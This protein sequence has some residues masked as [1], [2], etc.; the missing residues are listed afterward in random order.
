MPSEPPNPHPQGAPPPPES[1][2]PT[3]PEELLSGFS[4]LDRLSAGI[5][6]EFVSTVGPTPA[7]V[8]GGGS[9]AEWITEPPTASLD[10]TASMSPDSSPT[11]GI[12]FTAETPTMALPEAT[13]PPSPETTTPSERTT[14]GP[15]ARY[16]P[17]IPLGRGGMGEV[18][19][20]FDRQLGREIAIKRIRPELR[21]HPA[22]R[23]RFRREARVLARL[24]HPGV[25]PLHEVGE[26]QDGPWFSM[27]VVG[28]QGLDERVNAAAAN[29]V[30]HRADL[31]DIFLRVC[32][33]IAFAHAAGI[34][35][36]D[37]KPENIRIGDF[38][39]VQLLDWGLAAATESDGGVP[40][41][42][43]KP[44]QTRQG[45]L[46]GTPGW[47]A[48]EQAHGL[49][50]GAPADIWALGGLLRYCLTARTPNEPLP[51]THRIPRAL[52]AILSHAM[53]PTPADRYP[54]ALAL[55]ADLRAFLR[56]EPI[57][58]A[59]FTPIEHL[60]RILT[61]HRV[62][63]SVTTLLL[64]AT[65]AL[66]FG[67][68]QYRQA[69]IETS[70]RTQAAELARSRAH[71]AAIAAARQAWS[72]RD[73]TTAALFAT[74]ALQHE[75]T[76][77][78]AWGLVLAAFDRGIPRLLA[79]HPDPDPHGLWVRLALPRGSFILLPTNPASPL[80]CAILHSDGRLLPIPR[81]FRGLP[82][83]QEELTVASFDPTRGTVWLIT[84]DL[85]LHALDPVT[86][87]ILSTT[88]LP[89]RDALTT[90]GARPFVRGLLTLPD[91]TLALTLQ[92]IGHNLAPSFPIPPGA[93]LY[94][95]D[96][97]RAAVL[98][99]T[100]ELPH[101]PGAVFAHLPMGIVLGTHQGGLRIFDPETLTPRPPINLDGLDPAAV[102][103][104]G[105]GFAFASLVHS[106]PIRIGIGTPH[107]ISTFPVD[108]TPRMLT[109]VSRTSPP[110]PN[111][112][113]EPKP[114]LFI[115]EGLGPLWWDTATAS[116]RLRLP[117]LGTP[118]SVNLPSP[119]GNAL[120][121]TGGRQVRL[122]Q[123]PSP[124]GPQ[125]SRHTTALAAL[126]AGMG[127]GYVACDPR[128]RPTFLQ[129]PLWEPRRG[130]VLHGDHA[131][132]IE[133]LPD[134]ISFSLSSSHVLFRP[135][136]GGAPPTWERRG[137]YAEHGI[138]NMLVPG[139][140]GQAI[141]VDGRLDTFLLDG[142]PFATTPGGG[143]GDKLRALARVDYGT[144]H[145]LVGSHQGR[146]LSVWTLGPDGFPAG[147][148]TVRTLPKSVRPEI[149][150]LIDRMGT[151]RT[152][153]L[154]AAERFGPVHL[155]HLPSGET[156]EFEDTIDWDL[157]THFFGT[158][159]QY[160]A[161][162]GFDSELRIWDVHHARLLA[163]LPRWGGE[164]QDIVDG[165]P[166]E[167]LVLELGEPQVHGIA[168]G[169]LDLPPAELK[170]LLEA[171]TGFGVREGELILLP[172]QHPLPAPWADPGQLLREPH[173]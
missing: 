100:P 69:Q 60:E 51:G 115:Q 48:P 155:L 14:W 47:W 79:Q 39:E 109:A 50:S 173:Y 46:I 70:L 105:E 21:N 104:F 28:G 41:L 170:P 112:N 161:S 78:E 121:R 49:P 137:P 124:R 84:S 117:N 126:P 63:L 52:L 98:A 92:P 24:P 62:A 119:E 72:R 134:A 132:R 141:R 12:S 87:T 27:R 96:P 75:P 93:G 90:E 4:A 7:T 8:P 120:A 125:L 54:D 76:D 144:Q 81:T 13:T 19:R 44:F 2:T 59:P 1:A 38:G 82:D 20:T 43:G 17:G 99:F 128:D 58:V 80:L 122:T 145:Y 64:L 32:E 101:D 165:E 37:L 152:G 89:L 68:V 171:W 16:S 156:R 151:S 10:P 30:H 131:C 129:N 86:G 136:V 143:E 5:D 88:D 164:I 25:V 114:E 23:A 110:S 85:L 61:R 133:V 77:P 102:V 157:R 107:T 142:P 169:L 118:G 11:F 150:G 106:G 53:A 15:E 153:W 67:I 35:H 94:R 22:I 149:S 135:G 147:P 18:R 108:Q 6:S 127:G 71:L 55:A 111:G 95:I 166:G 26:D 66:T 36:R 33:A 97:D 159:D 130:E 160:L 168:V 91:G 45:T 42:P 123:L 116:A 65:L 83:E 103:P 162:G 140:N 139:P 172:D 3:V 57:S 113:R 148:P 40:E 34:V 154:A 138:Q 73:T 56:G 31:L 167:L 146:H 163:R 74:E 158:Q 9:D 29:L